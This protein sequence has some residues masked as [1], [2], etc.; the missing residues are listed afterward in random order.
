MLNC[1]GI[2]RSVHYTFSVRNIWVKTVLGRFI[3]DIKYLYNHP[4]PMAMGT[5]DEYCINYY[6]LYM[7]DVQF[8]AIV[9]YIQI[10]T[11]THESEHEL[12][13]CCGHAALFVLI[14]YHAL[15][16][17]IMS[18]KGKL[19]SS[20]A[21]SPDPPLYRSY[22]VSTSH[23]DCIYNMQRCINMSTCTLEHYFT[24]AF[25]VYIHFTYCIILLCFITAFTLKFNMHICAC[26]SRLLCNA[27]ACDI[28][29]QGDG[30][31]CLT[32]L[33]FIDP[34]IIHFLYE[35]FG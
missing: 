4:L 23:I 25:H 31:A 34:C 17:T 22:S 32:I 5:I 29:Q 11:C 35:I 19:A 30:T 1:T 24:F 16:I 27:H 3:H 2:H 14:F 6:S 10:S 21:P 28:D 8:R 7:R 20:Q 12:P 13:I 26:E 33:E 18:K 15:Y 9:M